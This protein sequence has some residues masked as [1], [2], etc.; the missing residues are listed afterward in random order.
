MNCKHAANNRKQ[1]HMIGN[2]HLDPVWL[3]KWPEGLGAMRA[4][5]RSAL[6]RMKETE[7]FVFTS[8]QAAMYEYVERCDPELFE[9]I[10]ERVAEGRWIIVGGWWVQPDCNIPGN[11]GFVRQAL[12]G[13]RYFKEKFNVDIRVGY[14]VDSFGH[15]GMLPQILKKTGMDYYVFMRPGPHEKPE[16]PGRIFQWESPDGSRVLAYQIPMSYNSGW[17][18]GLVEKIEKTKAELSESQ[19]LLMCFYGVGNHGGGPTKENLQNIQKAAEAA[20]DVDILLSDPVRYFEAL[21]ARGLDFP[22]VRDDLQHHASGCYSVHSEIKRNN[23]KAEHGLVSAEKLAS[24]AGKL[25]GFAY[26]QRDLTRAWKDVLFNQFHDIMA[27]TS[28]KEAY[29]DARHMHGRALQVAD[30]TAQL[31]L[32]AIAAKIDT[33]REGTPIVIWNPHGHRQVAPVAGELMWRPKEMALFTD[34]GEEIPYQLIETSAVIAPGERKAITFVADVPAGGYTV[35]WLRDRKPAAKYDGLTVTDDTLAHEYLELKIDRRTRYIERLVDKTT[36]WE[37]FAGDAAVPV[38]MYDSSDTW[39]HAVF[40]FDQEVGRFIDAKVEQVENGPVRGILRVTSQYGRS[41]IIQE[42]TM[43]AGLPYV[44]VKTTVDWRDQYKVLK[45]EFPVNVSNPQPTYEIAFG[46][47]QRPAD[48]EEEPGL[49]W[50][51]VTGDCENARYGLSIINDAKYSYD[52][53]GNRMRLTVL[54][55][56]VYAHHI[57][58]ETEPGEFYHFIDQGIQEFTY[59]LVPHQGEWQEAEPARLALELN[60]P[61]LVLEESNHGGNLPTTYSGFAVDQP[62]ILVSAIKRQEDGKG[63]ILRAYEA[64]GKS[65]AC[66]FKWHQAREWETHFEPFEIKTFLV[67]DEES[68]EVIE[69]DLLEKPLA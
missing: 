58:R 53:N 65:T 10:K 64:H 62:N 12:Y 19:P 43:Y 31:A 1:I 66:T 44:D 37:V 7:G 30:E 34:G 57:P 45:L 35:Y 33:A 67:P 68:Q 38:V 61:M 39:S 4:T 15:S 28:I 50:F 63:Y 46:V 3:W 6:D 56:P 42:F 23:R 18:N 36:G 54:R 25:V 11:E 9:E 51:D 49:H 17:S 60:A 40:R 47:I 32:Q 8:S 2:A 27:G 20:T 24:L 22:V 41:S 69:L 26:P 59:R 48:G 55:S 52:V 5:F 29:E 13:I 21:E 14:N 16:L